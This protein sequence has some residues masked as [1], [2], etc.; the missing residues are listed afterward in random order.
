MRVPPDARTR[1]RQRSHVHAYLRL[2]RT[3]KQNTWYGD[4]D[5][6]S[7]RVVAHQ[8]RTR[9]LG[10]GDL[11][12]AAGIVRTARSSG[13]FLCTMPRSGTN[14]VEA[15]VACGISL[16]QGG[17]GTFHL[18]PDRGVTGDDGW[19]FDGPRYGWPAQP[20]SLAMAVVQDRDRAVGD[21]LFVGS[22]D[23]LEPGLIDY[24][25]ARPVVTIREPVEAARS[26]VRKEGV[27]WT[28]AHP[29]RL[30]VCVDRV[31]RFLSIWERRLQ[32][33]AVAE[34]TLLLRY[35]DLRAEPV[36]ALVEIG[37]HWGLS[38]DRACWEEAG[39]RCS[40][41]AMAEQASDRTDTVRISLKKEAL[42]A[43]AEDYIRERGEHMGQA[44]GYGPGT[45]AP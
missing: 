27:A 2:L 7:W 21:P 37:R 39:A 34:R 41:S 3:P 36:A 42:P 10:A 31:D 23:P 32:D 1:S 16:S 14:W 20:Q 18:E 40:W 4:L 26:L 11:R 25:R 8:T 45:P 44:F 43:A 28:M 9:H 30:P 6:R 29:S 33:P 24:R 19:V 22:H 38:V 17:T 15:M 12:R 35:E 13:R 5:P